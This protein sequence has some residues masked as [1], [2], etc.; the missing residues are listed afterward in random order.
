MKEIQVKCKEVMNHICENLG[1]DLNSPRCTA[2]KQ[3]IQQCNCCSNYFK[4]VELTI[5]FY[6]KYNVELPE[7]AHNKLMKSLGLNE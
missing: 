5:D 3:H 6:K 4:T 1:E 2:I 7:N